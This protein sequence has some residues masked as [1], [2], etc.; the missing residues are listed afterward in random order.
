[1]F[2]LKKRKYFNGFFI[3]KIPRPDGKQENLGY[4]V[5]DEPS[6][7]QSDPHVLDLQL[8]SFFKQST[9]AK[10]S[11]VKSVEHGN[12]REIDNWIKNISDIQ[13]SKPVQIVNYQR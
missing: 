6:S 11:V 4:N 5:L 3:F 7:R 1:V 8:R 13:K 10:P 2:N 9:T 12:S